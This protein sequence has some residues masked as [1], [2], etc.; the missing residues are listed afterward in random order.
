MGK[1]KAGHSVKDLHL[2]PIQKTNKLLAT[3]DNNKKTKILT[4][5]FF[6]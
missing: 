4:E 2:P 3:S 5:R 6:P 1:K